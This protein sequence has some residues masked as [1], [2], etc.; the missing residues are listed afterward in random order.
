MT[1]PERT[2][3]EQPAEGADAGDSGAPGRT[4]HPEQAAEGDDVADGD[5][6]DTPD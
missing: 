3:P 2:H 4:P 5:S 6:A 1:E